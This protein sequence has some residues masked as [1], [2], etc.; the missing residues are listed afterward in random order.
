MFQTMASNILFHQE[1][2]SRSFIVNFELLYLL[3]EKK[4]KFRKVLIDAA[5]LQFNL[6]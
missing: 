3:T 2:Y 4:S 5:L 6:Q 1:F